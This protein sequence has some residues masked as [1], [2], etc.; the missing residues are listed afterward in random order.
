MPSP[1]PPAGWRFGRCRGRHGLPKPYNRRSSDHR[2]TPLTG[3]QDGRAG[4]HRRPAPAAR[5]STARCGG[6]PPGGTSRP[7]GRRAGDSGPVDEHERGQLR[8]FVGAVPGGQSARRVGAQDDDSAPPP[9][10]VV[11]GHEGCRPCSWV[12]AALAA[13]GPMPRRPGGSRRRPRPWRSG[14][15]PGSPADRRTSATGR[16]PPPAAPRPEPRAWRT[17]TAA[18]R[19]PMCG[20]VEGAARARRFAI[21]SRHPQEC[22][23]GRKMGRSDSRRPTL[24]DDAVT[25]R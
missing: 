18:R 9:D 14:P 2:T 20:R 13:R 11:P 4:G 21:R 12:A 25:C 10:R 22:R 16:W 15:R 19:C 6:S 1:V 24:H 17:F 5:C 3:H 8:Q 7:R 23:G